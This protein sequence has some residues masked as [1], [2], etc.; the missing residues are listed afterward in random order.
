MIVNIT[1]TV[2]KEKMLQLSDNKITQYYN[3]KNN[4]DQRL[5]IS[6]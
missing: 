2:E 1:V 4:I 6:Y 3:N 5:K